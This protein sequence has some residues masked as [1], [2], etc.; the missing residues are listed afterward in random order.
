MAWHRQQATCQTFHVL[1]EISVTTVTIQD[2]SLVTW[3]RQHT[4]SLI[5]AQ[6]NNTHLF[7]H[8]LH[9]LYAR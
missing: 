7:I 3:Q 6:Q 2:L 8:L 5:I 4:L 9:D 1:R